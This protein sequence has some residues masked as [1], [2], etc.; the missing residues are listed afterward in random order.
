MVKTIITF[1]VICVVSSAVGF[2]SARA[3]IMY[4]NKN[5]LPCVP[6]ESA[7]EAP[8]KTV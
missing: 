4:K 6:C 5:K 2:G 3:Y 1:I 8:L 7:K